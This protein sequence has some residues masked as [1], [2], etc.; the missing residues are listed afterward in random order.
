MGYFVLDEVIAHYAFPFWPG[1]R[2][3]EAWECVSG[4]LIQQ[5]L[6][7]VHSYSLTGTDVASDER[8]TPFYLNF[9]MV[10]FAR[11]IFRHLMEKYLE[12]RPQIAGRLP[13][14]YF[15]GQ[16]ALALSIAEMRIS[17]RSLPMRFNFPND[18]VAA[19][20]FPDE[21]D[22]VAVFHY[23]LSTAVGI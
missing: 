14:P 18:S 20:R 17:T 4:G 5:K 8:L 1:V 9:G 23:L 3:R 15:S 22:H 11:T 12:L 13:D 6:R 7:F 21:L 16:V 19:S 10:F 2:S